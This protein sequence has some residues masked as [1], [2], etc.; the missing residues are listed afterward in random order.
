MY[1]TNTY[2]TILEGFWRE[3][4]VSVFLFGHSK[5]LFRAPKNG[6]FCQNLQTEEHACMHVYHEILRLV[7]EGDTA[8]IVL[9]FSVL[10]LRI[11]GHVMK[12]LCNVE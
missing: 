5:T 10:A 12:Y 9:P 11:S 6:H 2:S 7:K 8:A 1:K 3:K 4:V